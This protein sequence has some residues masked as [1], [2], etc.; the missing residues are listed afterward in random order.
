[1]EEQARGEVKIEDK[2][3]DAIHTKN[4]D[5]QQEDLGNTLSALVQSSE[6]NEVH[7]SILAPAH[8]EEHVSRFGISKWLKA[9]YAHLTEDA[10]Y[11][12]YGNYVYNRKTGVKVFEQMP[13]YTRVGMHLLFCGSLEEA[14]VKGSYT[15]SVFERE[16]VAMGKKFDSPESKAKIPGFIKQF[17][18]DLSDL[19][20]QDI[21]KYENFNQFFSR[22]LKPGARP[23]AE[24]ENSHR[25]VSAADCRLVVFDTI[26][27]ARKYW[28]KGKQFT[29]SNLLQ[30]DD[31]AGAY[32]GGALAIFRL[33]PQDYH[34]WHSPVAGRIK[35]IKNLGHSLLS[36]NPMIVN[37]NLDVF[38]ENKRSIAV[39]ETQHSKIPVLVVAVGA[40]LVGSIK[41][42]VKEGD[43]IEK[44]QEMGMFLYGGSTVICVFPADFDV[45][46]DD[47]LCKHSM[48]GCETQVSVGESVGRLRSPDVESEL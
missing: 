1:M 28:V 10:A 13:I 6:D 42:T 27:L 5:G 37:E 26:D 35:M 18:L 20:V 3:K 44:G 7:E 30:S 23:V 29:I 34:R 31:Y 2:H 43:T 40:M 15:Q 47:D 12:R 16:S 11:Y 46:F 21:S 19:A 8:S 4:Y 14:M 48:E 45:K 22:G 39:V 41:W 17:N 38:T 9:G 24:P 33:A 32:T 25:I 36:V